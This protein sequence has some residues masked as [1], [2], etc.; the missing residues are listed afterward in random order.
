MP[1]ASDTPAQAK[2]KLKIARSLLNKAIAA[3]NDS[4]NQRVGIISRTGTKQPTAPSS[5][6]KLV[7]GSTGT[8]TT[9]AIRMEWAQARYGC[10]IPANWSKVDMMQYVKLIQHAEEIHCVPSSFHC[11]VDSIQTN[12]KLFFH[13]IREKTSMAVNTQWNN[14]KWNE[15]NYEYRI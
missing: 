4:Y 6:G 10:I 8:A 13:D 5:G 1:K 14:F 9:G 12:A 15:V 7:E 11:L 3:S 2:N